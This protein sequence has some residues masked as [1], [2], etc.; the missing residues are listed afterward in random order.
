MQSI[1]QTIDGGGCVSF[2]DVGQAGISCSGGGA[3]VAEQLLNMT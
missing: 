3:G 1:D 2:G